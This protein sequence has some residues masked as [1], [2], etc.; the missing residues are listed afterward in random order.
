[1]ELRSDPGA[2]QSAELERLADAYAARDASDA[3]RPYRYANAGYALYMQLLEWALLES[4][5]RAP[6]ELEGANV[7]D[8]GCG[9]GYFLHRL[10][11]F[12]AGAGTGVD[13]VPER[14][15]AALRRY[16]GSRFV[17]A[18]AA[19]LPFSD[20]EFDL[21]TQ[22]TC[23]SSVIDNSLR[24]AIVAEMWRVVRKGG[25]VLSYDMREPSAPVRAMRKLGNWRRGERPR[26]GGATT[27]TTPV[28]AEE[29]RR[30]FPAG[31]L[32]Y[33]TVGLA[34]GLCGAVARWPLAAQ[35]LA[36]VPAL[37]EHGIGVI[38]KPL[39]DGDA[40]S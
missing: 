22:F 13:L 2:R 17:C 16:P 15:E 10:I 26:N 31:S 37:R 1:M 5:R 39:P 20:G 9:S 34:F 29:L 19:E 40:A 14:I 23:L 11:E 4:L 36:R 33:T 24:G 38:A 12:G 30:L 8:V 18:N 35:L 21:V 28:S 3:A 25:I 27:P 7:L 6:V 32:Q